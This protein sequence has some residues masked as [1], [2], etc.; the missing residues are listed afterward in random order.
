[1]LNWYRMTS[2]EGD[3]PANGLAEVGV[4]E[5][6]AQTRSLRSQLEERLGNRTEETD[7]LMFWIP[8]Q[9]ANCVQIQNHGRWS[10]AGSATMRKDLDTSS[11]GVWRVSALQTCWSKQCD[12]RRRPKNFAL[13]L[14][15]TSREIRCRNLSHA[16][17]CE[18]RNEICENDGI[19]CS[20]QRVLEFC[21]N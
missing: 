9:A 18:K 8:R 12:V 2:P 5:I 4:S 10:N 17:R 21:G 6:K 3:H 19:A 11:G 7:P 1:M 14:C 20:S 16:R 13:C 15:G